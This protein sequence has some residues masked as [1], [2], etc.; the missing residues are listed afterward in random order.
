MLFGEPETARF[1]SALQRLREQL[2][3]RER[4]TRL[5]KQRA[6]AALRKARTA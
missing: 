3:R 2:R 5:A 6:R 1:L 4:L